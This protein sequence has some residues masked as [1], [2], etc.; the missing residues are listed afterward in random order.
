MAKKAALALG[1]LLMPLAAWADP[2]SDYEAL[3]A[4]AKDGDPGVDYTVMRQAYTQ[5]PDYDPFGK[6]T[7]GLMQDAQAAYIAGDCKTALA[8]FKMAIAFNFTLSDAHALS[9]DCLERAGDKKGEAREDAVAQGLFKSILGS[10][11]GRT[12]KTAIWVVTRHEEIVVFAVAGLN[13]KGQTTLSTERGPIDKFTITDVKTGRTGTM[14]FNVSAM[15]LS[16][17]VKSGSKQ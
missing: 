8:K 1:L 14:Y 15:V 11:D 6:K 17:G 9:A 3:V 12:P 7:D 16:G 2:T 10:G 4:A 5:T 13:G